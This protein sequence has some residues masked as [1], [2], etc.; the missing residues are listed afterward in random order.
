MIPAP[1]PQW[2]TLDL[3]DLLALPTAFL[4]DSTGNYGGVAWLT[5][6]ANVAEMERAQLTLN[7]D[8]SFIELIDSKAAGVYSEQPGASTQLIYRRI[9]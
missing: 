6:F 9:V 8:E 3:S 5:A 1:H 2:Q 4:A 7:T